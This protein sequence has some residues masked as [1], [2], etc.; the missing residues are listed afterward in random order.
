MLAAVAGPLLLPAAGR[1]LNLNARILQEKAQLAQREA[2]LYQERALSLQA[3]ME[4]Q[5]KQQAIL[6]SQAIHDPLTGLL[7]RRGFWEAAQ[8]ALQSHRA[9]GQPLSI[10]LFDID[11]F[12][13]VNDTFGHPAGDRMLQVIAI[14]ALQALRQNDLL[15]RYGGE[16]FIALLPNTDLRQ[17]QEVAERLRLQIAALRCEIEQGVIAVTI[18]LGVSGTPTHPG[19]GLDV[20]VDFLV[21]KDAGH[22]GGHRL[23]IDVTGKINFCMD[24]KG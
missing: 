21:I 10:I 23:E 3:E 15:S 6:Q 11:L 7:N 9:E 20:I 17:A 13:N 5:R 8:A 4:E 14:Q 22:V 2:E 16:E 12:K 18:S 24:L 1:R 19:V